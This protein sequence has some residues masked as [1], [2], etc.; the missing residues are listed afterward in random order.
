MMRLPSG[1]ATASPPMERLSSRNANRPITTRIDI[2]PLGSPCKKGTVNRPTAPEASLG[3]IA[4]MGFRNPARDCGQALILMP[5]AEQLH[6][7]RRMIDR[8]QG[9]VDGRR[10]EDR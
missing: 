9:Q 4:E 7:E 5:A 1:E 6:A 2:S 3:H 10:A 8:E